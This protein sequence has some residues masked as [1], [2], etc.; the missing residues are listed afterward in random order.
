MYDDQS[1]ASAKMLL[2]VDQSHI[3]R[4]NGLA[5]QTDN[6]DS[7]PTGD[8]A[9][10]DDGRRPATSGHGGGLLYT[11]INTVVPVVVEDK[12]A[13][14]DDE[15]NVRLTTRRRGGPRAAVSS[16]SLLPVSGSPS[17]SFNTAA[18]DGHRG[19]VSSIGGAGADF[20]RQPAFIS[21]G[22]P[23]EEPQTVPCGVRPPSADRDTHKVEL[24]RERN[25]LAAQKCRQRKMQQIALLRE[26]VEQLNRSKVQ[27]EG[28]ADDLRRQ[29][30]ILSRLLSQHTKAGCQLVRS[31]PASNFNSQYC[32]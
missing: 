15:G 6:I 9:D 28:T 29:V 7:W 21:L 8:L 26:R 12:E 31:T 20:F 10:S 17:Y 24:K 11:S 2:T 1:D 25:R 19:A 13:E 4:P 32:T 18:F 27:L 14:E 3:Y 22:M 30:N 16:T 5:Q 23:M